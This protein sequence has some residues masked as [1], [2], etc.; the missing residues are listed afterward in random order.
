MSR[1]WQPEDFEALADEMADVFS[2][3]S[4]E[5]EEWSEESESEESESEDETEDEAFDDEDEE[6]QIQALEGEAV[7]K[8]EDEQRQFDLV[9]GNEFIR[10]HYDDLR[11]EYGE[12]GYLVVFRDQ[13]LGQRAWATP[14]QAR[15]W[16]PPPGSI[17]LRLG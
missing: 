4:D 1:P 7:S 13:V 2:S 9:L 3:E 11:Q 14:A 17:L 8:E 12:Q 10:E 6:E 16:G 15:T 5:A